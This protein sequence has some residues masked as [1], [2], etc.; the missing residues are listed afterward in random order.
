MLRRTVEPSITRFPLIGKASRFSRGKGGYVWD[1]GGN[2][3]VDFICGMGPV[4]WGHAMEEFNNAVC[5][6]IAG[7]VILPGYSCHH[8]SYL[9][10][11]WMASGLAGPHSSKRV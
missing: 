10:R 4:V 11:L 3:Y 8:E 1:D 6:S 5:D 9:N 7:G 2:Q